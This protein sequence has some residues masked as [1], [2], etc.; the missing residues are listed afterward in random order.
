MRNGVAALQ[1]LLLSVSMPKNPKTKRGRE[2]FVLSRGSEGN[3]FPFLTEVPI[4]AT[5]YFA[6][7]FHDAADTLTEKYSIG[8][9]P[10]Y[11]VLPVVFLFRH[12][13]ELYLKS[14][15]W[16]GDDLLKF[17]KKQDS[18]AGK[19]AFSSHSLKHLLPY[20]EK[21]A[22]E[23][24]LEW[25]EDECGTYNNAVRIMEQMDEE[26]PNSFA[27]RYP[28]DKGG[29]PVKHHQ[30]GFDLESFALPTSKAL[31]GWWDLALGLEGVREQYL[32]SH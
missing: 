31:N 3:F 9:D 7:G 23:F 32:M 29:K 10:D 24:E 26:D 15:I 20:A 30:W 28:I 22:S 18:G 2:L 6:R 19:T 16:N 5:H 11:A 8:G 14:I 12:A 27:F 21:V 25:D 13:A 17:L 4:E 1:P